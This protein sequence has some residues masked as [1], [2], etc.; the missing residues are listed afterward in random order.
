MAVQ[1]RIS[2][3][4]L[5]K[6]LAKNIVPPDSP[7]FPDYQRN[8]TTFTSGFHYLRTQLK[9]LWVDYH[10]TASAEEAFTLLKARV[11]LLKDIY[12]SALAGRQ[13]LRDL[14]DMEFGT[15]AI[16]SGASTL[17]DEFVRHAAVF[18]PATDKYGF[19]KGYTGVS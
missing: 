17:I 18:D 10:R 12:S 11:L 16:L 19:Y 9:L 14:F 4:S 13:T 15:A 2:S 5:D 7:L 6:F 1:K 3:E 8:L